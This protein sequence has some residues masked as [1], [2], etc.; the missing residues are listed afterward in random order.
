MIWNL[1]IKKRAMIQFKWLLAKA[2]CQSLFEDAFK[3]IK[4]MRLNFIHSPAIHWKIKYLWPLRLHWQ[5]ALRPANWLRIT[6]LPTSEAFIDHSAWAWFML[7]HIT[8]RIIPLHFSSAPS[9]LQGRS[10][11]TPW[12]WERPYFVF[13]FNEKIAFVIH[14]CIQKTPEQIIFSE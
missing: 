2:R 13:N 8:R 3:A 12:E 4:G 10:H 7:R 1:L 5:I 9:K 6:K 11:N 14:H